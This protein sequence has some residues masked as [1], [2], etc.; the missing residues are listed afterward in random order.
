[1]KSKIRIFLL[2][3]FFSL[4]AFNCFGET[5]TAEPYNDDEFPQGLQDLRRFEIITL[6]SMPFITLDASIAYNTYKYF[7]G[8]TEKYHPLA[9]T[10]YSQKEME[11]IIISSICISTTIGLT[12]Y[13]I[14]IIKRNKAKKVLKNSNQEIQI[15]Q[16]ENDPDAI[17]IENPKNEEGN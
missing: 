12:D 10:N 14:R 5:K 13:I 15:S 7:D 4:I 16:I 17:K 2:S 3:I 6:G 11:N 8:Q 9:T 1:M